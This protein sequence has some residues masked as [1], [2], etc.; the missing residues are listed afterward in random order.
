[1]HSKN[2]LLTNMVNLSKLIPWTKKKGV[3]SL[4]DRYLIRLSIKN[5]LINRYRL[6]L[7]AASGVRTD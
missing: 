2:V 1:M 6:G 5:N 7:K 3:R 4:F